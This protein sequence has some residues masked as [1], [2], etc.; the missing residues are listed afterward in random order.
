MAGPAQP[1][2]MNPPAYQPFQYPSV[3][4]AGPL[5]HK[6]PFGSNSP[7]PK[8]SEPGFNIP[9]ANDFKEI[10]VNYK[11]IVIACFSFFSSKNVQFLIIILGRFET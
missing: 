4:Q 7:P 9:P 2:P 3:P 11:V 10:N 1:P 5:E 6:Y 8:F